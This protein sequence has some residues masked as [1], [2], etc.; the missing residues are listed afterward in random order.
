M[1]K[2]YFN[3]QMFADGGAEGGADAGIA[4]SGVATTVTQADDSQ[5]ET[6]ATD[7][8]SFDDLIKGDYKEDFEAKLQSAMD[9]RFKSANKDK[10]TVSKLAPVI[11]ILG[12]KYGVDASDL[13]KVDLDAL[14][15][16]IMDDDSYYED[17]AVKKGIPVKELKNLKKLERDNAILRQSLEERTK[18]EQSEKAYAELVRQTDSVKT[19]YPA[20]DLNTEMK[21]PNFGRLVA[22]G[23]PLQTAYEV[24]H[25]SEIL[26]AAMQFAVQKTK[27]NISKSIQSGMSRP[28]ENGVNNSVGFTSKIDPG[29]LTPEQRADIRRRVLERGEKITF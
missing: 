27:E 6:K 14:T 11:A 21:N 15:K 5:A 8:V 10:E 22:N 19:V 9:K 23:V 29:N 20:F 25:K 16:A 1:R 3:L 4:D 7:R 2:A 24:V 12:D 18:R 26:P 28:T 17:E 13:S